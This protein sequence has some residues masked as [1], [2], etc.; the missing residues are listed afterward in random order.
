MHLERGERGSHHAWTRRKTARMGKTTSKPHNSQE[1]GTHC[2]Q[3]QARQTN[4]PH[5]LRQSPRQRQTALASHSAR[6]PQWRRA[7]TLVAIPLKE[8]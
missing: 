2:C 3:A 8:H 1:G 4:V 7:D 6:H 5:A